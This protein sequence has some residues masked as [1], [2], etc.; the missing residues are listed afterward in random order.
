MS[1]RH[2][3]EA[4]DADLPLL[5]ALA[6]G[7]HDPA[8]G[9]LYDRYARRILALGTRL[10][11]DRALAE[12]LVQETFVGLLRAAPRFDASR[13]TVRALLFTIARRSAID[14][15]RRRTAGP[16]L[17]TELPLELADQG[18]DAFDALVAEID[19]RA[20]MAELPEQHREMLE[21][22]YDRDLAQPAIAERLGIPLGTVKS[23]TSNALRALRA[24]LD[25]T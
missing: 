6:D 17:T 2:S 12:D 1:A 21:L 23:R 10:L 25:E 7:R 4:S 14:L 24:A 13:G 9:V 11:G 18:D 15:H 5:R 3:R 8:A 20:A 19:L 16:G 22:A